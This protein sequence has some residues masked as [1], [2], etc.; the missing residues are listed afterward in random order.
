[1]RAI[2]LV[3]FS[4][5]QGASLRPGSSPARPR[6]CSVQPPPYFLRSNVRLRRPRALFGSTMTPPLVCSSTPTAA[7]PVIVFSTASPHAD[8]RP[9][10]RWPPLSRYAAGT[11]TS[12]L[13]RGVSSAPPLSLARRSGPAFML[14]VSRC[15]TPTEFQFRQVNIQTPYILNSNIKY[16]HIWLSTIVV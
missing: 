16:V 14:S 13:V 2:D 4:Q 12:S 9:S 3:R 15:T 5:A 11:S 7:R 1:V 10:C 8:R 6:P